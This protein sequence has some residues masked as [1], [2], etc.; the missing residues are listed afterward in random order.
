MKRAR[1]AA[2][3]GAWSGLLAAVLVFLHRT[4]P[5]VDAYPPDGSGHV[6]VVVRYVAMTIGWYLAASTAFSFAAQLLRVGA[7]VAVAQRVTAAPIHRLTRAAVGA[8][9]AASAI[10]P[11]AASAETSQP[12][13]VMVWVGEE[14][15]RATPAPGHTTTETP[16]PEA[17]HVVISPGDS[18]WSLAAARLTEQLH[19]EPSDREVSRYW[20][21]VIRAN[22]A[23]LRDAM[24]P[25]LI[26]PGDRVVLP[27]P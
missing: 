24:V 21:K 8:V 25:D 26:Y 5:V 2:L 4:E 23:H 11:T 15:G 10:V 13:P 20:L 17:R 16:Q 14:Q 1:A 9:F 22:R 3:L 19:R 27:P 7:A 12:V 6:I 18:L